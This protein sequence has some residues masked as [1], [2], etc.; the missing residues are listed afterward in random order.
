MVPATSAPPLGLDGVCPVQLMR[1]RN[2]G[3]QN[4]KDPRFTYAKGDPRYGVVHRGRTYLFSGPAEQQEFLRDP[5]R[6][7]P[8][9]S[10]ID[11]VLFAEEGRQVPGTRDWGVY[12]GDRIYLFAT[13]ETRARFEANKRKYAEVVYQAE[14]PGRGTMR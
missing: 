1:V 3:I 5:D 2:F 6:Y 14:N 13:A 7:S 9:M 10:G 8:V 12:F 11:P 4:R